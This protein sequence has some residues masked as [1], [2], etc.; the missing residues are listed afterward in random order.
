M[1]YC[2]IDLHA[3]YSQICVLDEDGEVA[4][5]SRVRTS[6]P[7]LTRFFGRREWMKVVLVCKGKGKGARHRS[8]Y[9]V[10][11]V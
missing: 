2:G 3:E 4:E 10:E 5:T 7:G 11:S 6:L 1:E 9:M 8:P